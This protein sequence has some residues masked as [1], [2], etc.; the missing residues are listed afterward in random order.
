MSK[1]VI[2]TAWGGALDYLDRSCGILVEPTSPTALVEGI[3]AAMVRLARSPAERAAM[4]HAARLKVE[5]DYDWEVK[6]EDILRVY[7]RVLGAATAPA[8][9]A[10]IAT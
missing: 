1:P 5:S 4:G 8:S 9:A 3:A 2:A 7:R 6:A 10:A